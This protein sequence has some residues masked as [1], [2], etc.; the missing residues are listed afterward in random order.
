MTLAPLALRVLGGN[1][2]SSGGSLAAGED[3]RSP[4]LADYE[5]MQSPLQCSR[6]NYLIHQSTVKHTARVRKK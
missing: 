4:T 5:L 6:P 3:I 2:R 1:C